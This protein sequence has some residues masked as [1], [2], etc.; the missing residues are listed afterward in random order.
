MGLRWWTVLWLVLA[1]CGDDSGARHPPDAPTES[2]DGAIDAPE[3]DAAPD[4]MSVAATAVGDTVAMLED[5]APIVISPLANDMTGTAGTL[6][7]ASFTQPTFGTLTRD[8][9]S[10]TYTPLAELD[11]V[12]AF[13]YTLDGGSSAMV[14]ISVG[15]VNDAP[16]FTK[17]ADQTVLQNSAQK[18]VVGWATEI[19]PGPP[20]EAAQ[21]LAFTVTAANPA[22]FDAQPA[23]S[24]DG[25]LTFA[26]A[27]NA[28]GTTVVT[29]TLSDDGGTDNAG[30]DA[31]AAVTFTI[32]IKAPA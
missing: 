30:V 8:G 6:V 24:A 19:L 22:L 18:T 16:A 4:A 25:T 13:S 12:A 20:N 21:S 9:D 31:T 32:L 10:F 3:I 26:P 23:I 29:I 17:G 11:G 7:I 28:H 2:D 1:A 14:V 5:G 27:L 15:A